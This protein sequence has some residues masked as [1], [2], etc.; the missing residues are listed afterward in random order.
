MAPQFLESNPDIGLDVLDQ[1]ANVNMAVCVRQGGSNK[2]LTSHFGTFRSSKITNLGDQARIGQ[3]NGEPVNPSKPGVSDDTTAW[4]G[5][6]RTAIDAFSLL[7]YPSGAF[8]VSET[9][10]S[11]ISGSLFPSESPSIFHPIH[12]SSLEAAP[13]RIL[14]SC[15]E[16]QP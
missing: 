13:G 8:R 16:T 4:N 10:D 14:K 5:V 1:M 15:M 6:R 3:D 9:G 11:G 7:K 2:N 12:H